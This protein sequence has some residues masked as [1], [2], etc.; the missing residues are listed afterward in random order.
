MQLKIWHEINNQ[1][2]LKHKFLH[3]THLQKQKKQIKLILCVEGGREAEE[4]WTTQIK[5]CGE[6]T[7]LF[8]VCVR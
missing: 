6:F 8:S 1:I 3:M 7:E 4:R 2:W 5:D